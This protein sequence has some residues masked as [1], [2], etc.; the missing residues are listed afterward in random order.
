MTKL[1]DVNIGIPTDN[2]LLFGEPLG[3]VNNIYVEYPVIEK[4]RDVAFHQAWKW[5]EIDMAEDSYDVKNPALKKEV[6][7]LIETLAFQMAGDSIAVRSVYDVLMPVISNNEFHGLCIE[8]KRQ[9]YVH[10]M[11]YSE[12]L[13]VAFENASKLLDYISKNE[14]VLKRAKF[15]GKIFQEAYELFDKYAKSKPSVQK[16]MLPNVRLMAVKYFSTLLL[17]EAVSFKASFAS[18]FALVDCNNAFIRIGKNI[19]LIA[20]DEILH[21]EFGKEILG[22]LMTDPDYYPIF[23]SEEFVEW[24]HLAINEVLKLEYEWCDYLFSE[25]RT[26]LKLN[27]TILKE[28]ISFSSKYVYDAL[29]LQQPNHIAKIDKNPLLWLDEKWLVMD[30]IQNASQDTPTNNYKLNSVVYDFIDNKPISTEYYC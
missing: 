5:D 10:G 16:K 11:T 20:K 24:C 27:A 21:A 1:V 30:D 28:Y 26:I 6:D 23:K 29:K 25:G 2:K 12:I 7:I 18:T 19:Q 8:W 15:V 9:E 17:L 3:L 22:C 14:K 4:L 13:R